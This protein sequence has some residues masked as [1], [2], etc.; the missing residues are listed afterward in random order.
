MPAG[1]VVVVDGVVAVVGVVPT[2]GAAVL[3]EAALAMA[4]PPPISAPVTASPAMIDLI[5]RISIHLL[6]HRMGVCSPGPTRQGVWG[7]VLGVV[8]TW[9]MIA[10]Q[11]QRGLG[12]R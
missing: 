11:P 10:G 5:C 12:I 1:G 4:A 2:S 9:Q 8:G 6:G 7:A 3:V